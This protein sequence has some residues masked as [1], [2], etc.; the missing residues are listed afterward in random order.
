MKKKANVHALLEEEEEERGKAYWLLSE[1]L[2][3]SAV[4]QGSCKDVVHLHTHSEHDD[5]N[6]C[7]FYC[8]VLDRHN[9]VIICYAVGAG[10]NSRKRELKTGPCTDI[11][12][13]KFLAYFD[14]EL[15]LCSRFLG[16][17]RYCLVGDNRFET[18]DDCRRACISPAFQKHRCRE[19]RFGFCLGPADRVYNVVFSNGQC[20]LTKSILCLQGDNKFLNLEECQQFCCKNCNSEHCLAP[21]REGQCL[22]ADLRYRFYFDNSTN[23]CLVHRGV[24][25]KG[26]NRYRTLE[27]CAEHFPL[28]SE[29]RLRCARTP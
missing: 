9:H 13:Q 4:L 20:R 3:K 11:N 17:L 16:D 19:V 29:D 10:L 12:E 8:L 23:Q 7:R 15:N 27:T 26:R 6:L 14:Y 28:K 2:R 22:S 25:L 18:R 5:T 21:P 24:C 1:Q